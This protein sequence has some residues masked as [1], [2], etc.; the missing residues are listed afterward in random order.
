MV[1]TQFLLEYFIIIQIINFNN[2][3]LLWVINNYYHPRYLI[4]EIQST[5]APFHQSYHFDI[6]VQIFFF[7]GI[8]FNKNNIPHA[9][10]LHLTLNDLYLRDSKSV[11][12]S[13]GTFVK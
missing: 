10:F 13:H 11:L 8:N 7:L 9:S 6:L 1:N 2:H 12:Q 4:M 3:C 5:N